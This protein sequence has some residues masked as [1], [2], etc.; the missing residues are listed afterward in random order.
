MKLKDNMEA[1]W[2]EI[3]KWFLKLSGGKIWRSQQSFNELKLGTELSALVLLP[4]LTASSVRSFK[5]RD[6]YLAFPPHM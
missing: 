2:L 3:I 4:I 1:R 5:Y 6:S